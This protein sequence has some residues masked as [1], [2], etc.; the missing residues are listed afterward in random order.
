MSCGFNRISLCLKDEDRESLILLHLLF[1]AA[2]PSG[3]GVREEKVSLWFASVM[4]LGVAES[5]DEHPRGRLDVCVWL[6]LFP[7]IDRGTQNLSPESTTKSPESVLG[8]MALSSPLFETRTRTPEGS[9]CQRSQS[10]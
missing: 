8:G 10:R 9:A 5:V 7:V 6:Q 4:M 2:F 3:P 1:S